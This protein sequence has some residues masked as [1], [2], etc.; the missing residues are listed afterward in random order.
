MSPEQRADLIDS[1]AQRMYRAYNDQGPNPWKTF[2]GRSVP[3]WDS[4]TE[5]VRGKWKAA[6]AYAYAALTL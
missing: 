2:D 5:Q 3:Q 1:L 6:A 4:I